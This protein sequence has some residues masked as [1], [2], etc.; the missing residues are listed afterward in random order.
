[1]PYRRYRSSVAHRSAPRRKLV[2]ADAR[3]S[4]A[5]AA[6]GTWTNIDLLAGFKATVGSSIAGTTVYRILW[7]IAPTGSAPT[8]GDTVDVGLIVDDVNQVTAPANSPLVVHPNGDPYAKWMHNAR[9]YATPNF[10]NAAANNNIC[11]DVRAKRKL[12]EVGETPLLSI[13]P[14]AGTANQTWSFFARV[15]LALP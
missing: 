14:A 2:W 5:F 6:L 10:N 7:C 13:Q 11:G 12:D 9:Y 3:G 1:V 4:Q 15:L 8:L